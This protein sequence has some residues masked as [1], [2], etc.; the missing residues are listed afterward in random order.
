MSV[1]GKAILA[2][3]LW[4]CCF[5][6]SVQAVVLNITRLGEGNI[7]PDVGVHSYSV[8]KAVTITATPATGWE[9]DHWEGDLTGTGASQTA[10]LSSDKRVTVVFRP[11]EATP[12]N[13]LARYV[14]QLDPNYQWS[15]YDYDQHFGWN[16]HT[17]RMQSQQWRSSSE[18]DRP[19]WTHDVGIIEPWFADNRCALF[20]NGG[21]NHSGPPQEVDSKLSA[22]AILYGI[23]YAQLDQVPNEPLFFTDEVNNARTE[24]E[25]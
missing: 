7:S 14:G 3:A 21:S 18:V 8:G 12:A 23:Y 9:V 24:D 2:I 6:L 25:I 17:I 20:I 13:A 15:L 1:L 22:V 19:L 11:L 10:V 4:H 5:A 16:K